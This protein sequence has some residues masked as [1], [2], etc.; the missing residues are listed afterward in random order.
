MTTDTTELEQHMEAGGRLRVTLANGT[1][2]AVYLDK[3]DPQFV[4]EVHY[5]WYSDWAGC[6]EPICRAG[7]SFLYRDF[8][9]GAAIT[10]SDSIYPPQ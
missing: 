6:H 2:G 1:T 9:Q 7:D 3:D 8:L 5:I 4:D 10:L